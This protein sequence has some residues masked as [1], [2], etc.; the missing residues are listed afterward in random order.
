MGGASGLLS[1]RAGTV[2]LSL[3]KNLPRLFLLWGSAVEA[4]CRVLGGMTM[5]FGLFSKA[6]IQGSAVL[7]KRIR[8]G[9]NQIYAAHPSSLGRRPC[10][11]EKRETEIDLPFQPAFRSRPQESEPSQASL[12]SASR[13]CLRR[14]QPHLSI[15]DILL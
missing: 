6:C 9:E 5:M 10:P 2:T 12:I 7:P 14:L 15:R 3:H 1:R 13:P 11:P 4:T 8:L